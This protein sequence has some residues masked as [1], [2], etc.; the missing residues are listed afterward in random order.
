MSHFPLI[1]AVHA[2]LRAVATD[3]TPATLDQLDKTLADLPLTDLTDGAEQSVHRAL[4][5]IGH[6]RDHELFHAVRELENQVTLML[7]DGPRLPVHSHPAMRAVIQALDLCYTGGGAWNTDSANYRAWDR[8]MHAG[9]YMVRAIS[10]FLYAEA[11]HL[12]RTVS[13]RTQEFSA[14]ARRAIAYHA[15]DLARTALTMTAYDYGLFVIGTRTPG[16]ERHTWT[17]RIGSDTFQFEVTP[18]DLY[19]AAPA[20]RLIVTSYKT[21]QRVHDLALSADP[22]RSNTVA[23][24]LFLI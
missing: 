13:E 22:E 10:S 17:R 7:A 1:S 18:P 4:E 19:R 16:R 2:A 11:G 3:T 24:A 21:D 6:A 14:A 5:T 9:T 8:A 23:N 20:G 12:P 15:R